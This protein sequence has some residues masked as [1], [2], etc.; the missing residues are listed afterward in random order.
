[1]VV[2]GYRAEAQRRLAAYRELRVALAAMA[3]TV[4]SPE[5]CVEVTVCPGG[6]VTGLRLS[7]GALRLGA[8]GLAQAVLATVGQAQAR[9]A[10]RLARRARAHLGERYDVLP[11]MAG[12]LPA[13]PCPADTAVRG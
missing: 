6:A 7:D 2:E 3:V 12:R 4:R 5:G 1:M 10:R 9:L 11:V 8:D 13:V